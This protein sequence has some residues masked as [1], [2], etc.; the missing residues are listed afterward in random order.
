MTRLG[1]TLVVDLDPDEATVLEGSLAFEGYEISSQPGT[2]RRSTSDSLGPILRYVLPGIASASLAARTILTLV[3]AT[4]QGR[5]VAIE[6]DRVTVTRES[7]L[8]RGVIVV[9][10][11]GTTVDVID[12]TD[13]EEPPKRLTDLIETQLANAPTAPAFPLLAIVSDAIA[14]DLAEA[15]LATV[16]PGVRI[17][18]SEAALAVVG[19]A[20]LG[21]VSLVAFSR[22]PGIGPL[23]AELLVRRSIESNHALRLR[24]TSSDGSDI[25]IEIDGTT[26]VRIVAELVERLRH[27]PSGPQQRG[28]GPLPS[29]EPD[30]VSRKVF[31][32]HGRDLQAAELIFRVLR[33]VDLRPQEWEQIVKTNGNPATSLADAITS[34]LAVGAV[35]AVVAVLTPDDVVTLHEQLHGDSEDDFEVSPQMQPRPNVLLEL[36]WALANYP[37]QTIMIQFGHSLRPIADLAGLNVIRFD[38]DETAVKLGK[39]INRLGMAGCPVDLSGTDWLTTAPFR[40]IDAYT[41]RPDKHSS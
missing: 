21:G 10:H 9:R 17:A 12:L 5:I 37:E 23:V 38:G 11:H 16:V 35:Q 24:A 27:Q 26:D 4:R 19:G 20:A 2:E 28:A 32:V 40:D 14:D 25:E 18:P 34:G 33:T 31:V 6:G 29:T 39:L 22:I 41:R 3:K 13:S 8:P 7:T 36:G 30:D 1:L 15:E